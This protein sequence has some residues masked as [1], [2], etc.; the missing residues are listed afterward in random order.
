MN[1][2][3]TVKDQNLISLTPLTYCESP[4]SQW[5]RGGRFIISG[6]RAF[7]RYFLFL[8][9]SFVICHL[10]FADEVPHFYADEVVVTA[11][12][13]PQLRSRSPWN[14]SVIKAD[15]AKMFGAETVAD[16]LRM[17][18]GVDIYSV[19]GKGALNTARIKGANAEEVLVLV[20]GCRINSPLLGTVDMAG[21]LL[22]N[23]EKIEIVTA[24]LSSL[25][26]SDAVGGVINIITQKSV[27]EPTQVLEADYGSFADKIVKYVYGND[28]L[29]FTASYDQLNGFRQNSDFGSQNFSVN[30][31]FGHNFGAF[32]LSASYFADD[33]GI[34]GVP[35]SAAD[36]TSASTPN[37]RQQDKNIN[38]AAE[39]WNTLGNSDITAKLW[40]NTTDQ[41]YQ[42]VYY[43]TNY[44]YWTA[45]NGI[46]LQ[47]NIHL[48]GDSVLGL[49]LEYRENSGQSSAIGNHQVNEWALFANQE[50]EQGPVA[51]SV[52][53]RVDQ[54]STAGQ[55]I[56]P[57]IGLSLNSANDWKL[58]GSLATAMKAPTLNE[59]YWN[60]PLWL[61]YGDANL[62]SEKS[63]GLQMGGNKY[64]G[65]DSLFGCSFFARQITDQI[66]WEFSPTT[67]ITQAR[68][69][70]RVEVT[71][72]DFEYKTRIMTKFI[73]FNLF[74]NATFQTAVDKEDVTTANIGKDVP[75]SPRTKLNLGVDSSGRLGNAALIAK[76][77]GERFADAGNTIKLNPYTVVDATWSKKINVVIIN[78]KINNLFNGGY[79]EA[80]GYHPITFAILEY[81]MP[82]RSITVGINWDL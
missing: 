73:G 6:V 23:V 53:L 48:L 50:V 1:E 46:N 2:K 34:P 72:A 28:N 7:F 41:K 70:G 14:V 54:H 18:Q 51:M 40:Q 37:N 65:R 56:S 68:N 80:I 35:N 36:P 27:K 22:D 49:G 13:M 79:A 26:G 5:E 62:R 30:K 3:S 63:I 11:S 74:A 15:K 21:L 78:A 71:G 33:K 55:S 58:F 52:G 44:A 4:L 32:N 77:V 42:D 8:N 82:G 29:F 25:Y 47:D 81:P 59:L 75:Y 76:Y 24:P 64:F 17:A 9:L 67:F 12:R 38:L 31:S 57:R 61:M 39:Y 43:A 45:Q 19:G 66:L 60:D 69:A 20:D 10:S 16:A